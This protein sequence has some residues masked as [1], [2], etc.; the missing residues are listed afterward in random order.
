MASLLLHFASKLM[1]TVFESPDVSAGCRRPGGPYRT[2]TLISF[3]NLNAHVNLATLKLSPY[4][5]RLNYVVFR[6]L[7]D[8][9]TAD[10]TAA[11]DKVG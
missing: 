9:K 2:F 8:V 3:L 7:L 4:I 11:R 1:S 10:V 6:I 5:M